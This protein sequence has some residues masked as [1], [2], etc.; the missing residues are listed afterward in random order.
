M[1]RR[2]PKSTL[3]P[4]TTLFRSIPDLR[5]RRAADADLHEL[6]AHKS[7]CLQPGARVLA[8][9]LDSVPRH[10]ELHQDL[11]PRRAQPDPRHAAHGN[12]RQLHRRP[13]V[14]SDDAGEGGPERMLHGEIPAPLAQEEDRPGEQEQPETYEYSYRHLDPA[15]RFHER[16]PS[17]PAARR[18]L[19]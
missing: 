5:L 2:P 13:L 1:I 3:F 8:D 14:Q 11:L 7:H 12:A 4:Y 18:A 9:V 10:I 17:D 15:P 16:T 6:V 19:P